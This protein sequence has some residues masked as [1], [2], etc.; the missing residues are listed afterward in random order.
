MLWL[1]TATRIWGPWTGSGNRLAPDHRGWPLS[2]DR[3]KQVKE[4]N[5]IVD[6]VGSYLAL[7]QVGRTY[8]GLC[9]F[10][11]DSRPSFDV[12]PDRARYAAGRA[13]SM[14]TSSPSCRS[15]R[16]SPSA[17]RWSCSPDAPASPWTTRNA[18]TRDRA[19]PS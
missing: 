18:P 19:A 8:K 9:P 1:F 6:V 17:R 3:V 15:S 11:D 4:A 12:D 5:N 14:A 2:D 10:H 7:R 16:R 13:A